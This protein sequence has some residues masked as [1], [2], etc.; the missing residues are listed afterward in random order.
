MTWKADRSYNALLEAETG[1]VRKEGKGYLRVALVYP[2]AYGMGM[3]NL[4][5]QTV[6]GLLNRMAFVACERAFLPAPPLPD[7]ADL[8]TLETGRR[9]ADADVVAFSISFENDYLHLLTILEK[10][11]LNLLSDQR[12]DAD[13]LVMAGGVACTINPEPIAPFMD[14]FLL[15]EAEVGLAT[16]FDMLAE[17]RHAEDRSSLLAR[18]SRTVPGFYAP[19]FYAPSYFPD[20][21]LRDV[22]ASEGVPETVQRPYAADLSDVAT[23]SEVLAPETT[24]DNAF[25]IEVSRGC[26]HGCRFC[27]AGYV[28]R[29]P[30]FRSADTVASAIDKGAALSGH[31]GLVGA[32]VSDF[33]EI[34][35]VCARAAGKGARLSFSSLR[36]DALT[37]D[38]LA[39]LRA[40]GVKTAAI[41]PD[42]GSERMRRVIN[43]GLTETQILD[44]A[45]TLVSGS[46]PNL[47]LYFM[48]GL[49]TETDA[50]AE[51]I[52]EL[53]KSVKERFLAASR[54]RG[55][56]GVIT[57]SLNSFV[58][59]P[60]TPFQWAA[61]AD[62]TTLKRRIQLIRKGL[63]GVANLRISAASPRTAHVQG[64]LS[65]GDRRISQVLMLAH[66]NGGNWAKTFKTT[67]VPPAFYTTR[68]RGASERFPWEVIDQGVN[69][70]YL[71]REYQ[72]ALSGKITPPCAVG[73]C[74]RCGVCTEE[75]EPASAAAAT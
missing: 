47:K 51:A 56:I 57:V 62:A 23:C 1:A 7:R 3:S 69:R 54:D 52:V 11:G 18:L 66:E 2:N 24:F 41:A 26:P 34:G 6:Y 74:R 29:P 46:I 43:K 53:C 49:P 36:A 70:S 38:L 16:L 35:H 44:A 50:D 33:P 68:P 48:I 30:R 27:S 45:E 19:R 31:I 73:A 59:K 5:F 75:A 40:S 28:Y 42:G 15:G 61:M 4:G 20:G 14:G 63:K 12:T 65:R 25:L 72:R 22:V 60:F 37:G 71:W 64:L 17:K 58:P 39:V 32:A 8:V 10:A 13:P 55:R 67:P 9:L 21:R